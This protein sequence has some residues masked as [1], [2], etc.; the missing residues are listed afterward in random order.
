[1]VDHIC[2]RPTVDEHT[3]SKWHD[4]T[5]SALDFALGDPPSPE[6][7]LLVGRLGI[8]VGEQRDLL[9]STAEIVYSNLFGAIDHE[10][11][12]NLLLATLHFCPICNHNHSLEGV[13]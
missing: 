8:S 6:V 12:L 3:L 1:M 13:Q 4:W 2:V 11:T 7:E 5:N 10:L 9:E